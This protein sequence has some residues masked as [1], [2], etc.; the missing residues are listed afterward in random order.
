MVHVGGVL[1]HVH[2]VKDL[3]FETGLGMRL[4]ILSMCGTDYV[5]NI[6]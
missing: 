6:L 3:I 4:C 2:T 1:I 5:V